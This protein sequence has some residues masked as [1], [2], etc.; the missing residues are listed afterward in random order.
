MG[1]CVYEGPMTGGCVKK[2]GGGIDCMDV[3]MGGHLGDCFSSYFPRLPSC[4]IP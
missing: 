2:R 1:G 3:N 4:I